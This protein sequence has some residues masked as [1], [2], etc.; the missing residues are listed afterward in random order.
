MK[1]RYILIGAAGVVA[2]AANAVRVRQ[3]RDGRSPSAPADIGFMLAMHAA[4][5]RDLTRLERTAQAATPEVLAG[6]EVL[7]RRLV[8][9][10]QAED[11]DLWPV[12]RAKTSVPAVE[13]ENLLITGAWGQV[14]PQLCD[15]SPSNVSTAKPTHSRAGSNASFG[16]VSPTHTPGARRSVL[17]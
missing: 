8:V 6:W 3:N 14:S 12:L 13:A 15:P 2:I 17:S 16:F 7:S 11:E 4:F 9:H 1:T 10:H 5:R